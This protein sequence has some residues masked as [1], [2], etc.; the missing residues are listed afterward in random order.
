M[1]RLLQIDHRHE[2]KSLARV[3]IGWGDL[4]SRHLFIIRFFL[5]MSFVP[6]SL[7][8]GRRPSRMAFQSLFSEKFIT[9]H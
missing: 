6:M 2:G 3:W 9:F 8:V 7:L 4:C 1:P 5:G